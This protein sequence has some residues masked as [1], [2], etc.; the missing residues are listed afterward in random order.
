[1]AHVRLGGDSFGT[2]VSASRCPVNAEEKG[3]VGI[4]VANRR[5]RLFFAAVRNTSKIL[6]RK[7]LNIQMLRVAPLSR[8]QVDVLQTFTR[9]LHVEEGAANSAAHWNSWQISDSLVIS[10][11]ISKWMIG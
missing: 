5:N 11:E 8:L 10:I 7:I 3:V 9:I 1:V 2:E 4:V 6:V